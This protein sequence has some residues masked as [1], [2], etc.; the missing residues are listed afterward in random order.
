LDESRDLLAAGHPAEALTHAA[1]A[2]AQDESSPDASGESRGSDAL[3]AAAERLRRIEEGGANAVEV[4]EKVA[5]MLEYMASTWRL[6]KRPDVSSAR[7]WPTERRKSAT[8]RPRRTRARPIRRANK[9]RARVSKVPPVVGLLAG[10]MKYRPAHR[11]ARAA[12]RHQKMEVGDRRAPGRPG[13]LPRSLGRT[14]ARR[15]G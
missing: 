12:D 11:P 10:P 15:R 1:E 9:G 2:A 7:A 3:L 6:P 4:R 14:A 13:A 5:A 8:A